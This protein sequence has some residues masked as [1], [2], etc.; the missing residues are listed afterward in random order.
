VLGL[1]LVAASCGGDS[2]P[3]GYGG[4]HRAGF[5]EECASGAVSRRTCGCFYDRVADEVPFD[6]FERLDEE[7]QDPLPDLP[8]ELAALAA[9]C[10][11]RH[12]EADGG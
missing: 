6:R 12:E 8:D 10:A 7:M 9:G 4:D 2:A 11:A 3:G 1:V 5:L